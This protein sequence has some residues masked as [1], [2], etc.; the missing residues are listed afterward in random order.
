MLSRSNIFCGRWSRIFE[1]SASTIRLRSIGYGQFDFAGLTVMDINTDRI[2]E[3]VSALLYLG[4]RN[5]EVVPCY[6]LARER[7]RRRR[8]AVSTGQHGSGI[9][10]CV[11]SG[12]AIVNPNV[13]IADNTLQFV[14][15][16]PCSRQTASWR[17]NGCV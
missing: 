1:R 4:R 5:A 9:W 12:P 15:I 3:A 6:G 10:G 16:V 17:T 8:E 13:G 2:G 11:A 14:R 7:E